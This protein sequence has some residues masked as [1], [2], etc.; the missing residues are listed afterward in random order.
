MHVSLLKT[1]PDSMY[2]DDIRVKDGVWIFDAKTDEERGQGLKNEAS[3]RLVPVHSRLIQLWLMEYVSQTRATDA[4]RLFPKL[5]HGANGFGDRV[6]KSFARHL[7]QL[8][9]NDPAKVLH[10]ATHC[11]YSST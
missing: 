3:V 11:D 4:L 9:I 6:G 5:K 2:L 8:G 10:S 1:L 7:K